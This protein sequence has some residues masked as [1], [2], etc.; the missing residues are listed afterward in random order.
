MGRGQWE[1]LQK[2]AGK[3]EESKQSVTA[4]MGQVFH[5]LSLGMGIPG[6]LSFGPLDDFTLLGY[7]FFDF[8]GVVTHNLLMPL[9][10]LAMCISVGWFWGPGKIIAHVESSG[11][12]FRLKKAWLFSIRMLA[13]LM[14]TAVMIMGLSDVYRFI[15]G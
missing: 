6:A 7:S 12:V 1:E 10:G 13:P 9:G 4:A 11:V 2:N 5:S 15:T 3:K 14:V 8:V